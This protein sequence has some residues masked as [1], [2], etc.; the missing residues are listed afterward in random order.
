MGSVLQRRRRTRVG[1]LVALV[2]A[3]GL[4]LA[5]CA[6]EYGP[7]ADPAPDPQPAPAAP[8]EPGGGDGVAGEEVVV[9]TGG[10]CQALIPVVETL[11][12]P[13]Q[14]DVTDPAAAQRVYSSYLGEAQAKADQA[15]QEVTAAGAPPLAAGEQ[16]GQAVQQQV[17]DLRQDVTEARAQLDR[18]DPGNPVAI[19]QAVAAAGNVLGS[20]GSNVQAIGAL[21]S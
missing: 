14:I 16:L 17:A 12:T 15:L 13:P 7:T 2:A 4:A 21:T 8:V 3:T 11:R 18:A 19:G 10:V 1:P 20:A 9:W 5:G 6:G